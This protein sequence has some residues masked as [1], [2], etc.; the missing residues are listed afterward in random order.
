MKP[1]TLNILGCI[2]LAVGVTVGIII[3]A[4]LNVVLGIG[5]IVA[6]ILIYFDLLYKSSVL[7]ESKKQSALLY[8]IYDITRTK[9]NLKF[10]DSEYY[11]SL[12]ENE[13]VPEFISQGKFK[14]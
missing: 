9:N 4:T 1:K 2:M 13:K 14:R 12:N 3:S 8:D 10:E 7:E 5:C 6:G 11:N